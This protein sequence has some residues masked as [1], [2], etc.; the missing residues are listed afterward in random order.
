M[1]GLVII[2]FSRS[3]QNSLL[4]ANVNVNVNVNVNSILAVG[5]EC[6]SGSYSTS[7]T[8]LH[9]TRQGDKH[10]MAQFPQTL[11][12][13]SIFF[14]SPTIS[15]PTVHEEAGADCSSGSY[16][17]STVLLLLMKSLKDVYRSVYTLL[18][19]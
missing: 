14:L 12:S 10:Y 13:F 2:L 4:N 6:I 7:P 11:C 3:G 5:S 15:L 8:S 19:G 1:L 16:Y 9:S 18:R 17:K